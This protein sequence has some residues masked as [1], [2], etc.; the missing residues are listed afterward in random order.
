MCCLVRLR[1]QQ[2]RVSPDFEV[3]NQ[4][5][6]AD[7][8][9]WRRGV[10]LL[11]TLLSPLLQHPQP[12]TC[13]R[14]LI[15]SIIGALPPPPSSSSSHLLWIAVALSPM[16]V[17]SAPRVRKEMSHLSPRHLKYHIWNRQIKSLRIWIWA[18]SGRV[19]LLQILSWSR[20]ALIQDQDS[21]R[22]Y[23]LHNLFLEQMEL[24]SIRT[25]DL[26]LELVLNRRLSWFKTNT[27]L[28]NVITLY[29]RCTHLQNHRTHLKH[30]CTS[31]VLEDLTL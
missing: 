24:D 17:D 19:L 7:Q 8:Q 25:S 1:S 6:S 27:P 31:V 12:I 26:P 22:T 28:R 2:A 14:Q 15:F 20:P 18:L 23:T 5:A 29:I 21:S 4:N 13:W 30:T 9:W 16:F 11:F 10:P 3:S